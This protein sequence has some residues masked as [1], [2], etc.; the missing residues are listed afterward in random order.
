MSGGLFATGLIGRAAFAAPASTILEYLFFL[1]AYAL[2]G[3]P[4]LLGALRALR[5]GSLFNELS[6]MGVASLGAMAIGELPEAAAV[7]IFYGLGEYLQA[8]A[9]ARSRRSISELMSLRP[10]TVRL[11]AGGTRHS[12]AP[13][14]AAP[15]DI[16]EILPGERVALDGTVL[17]GSSWVDTAPMTGESRPRRLGLGDTVLGGFINGEGRLLA[18][19]DK[20]FG[21]SAA[22]RILELVEKAAARKAPTERFISRFAAVYTPLV[23]AAALLTALLPP[24]LIPDASWRTWIYRALA[25]LMT[26]CP[27]ALVVSIPLAYFG[28]LGG[29][30]R[31]K[32]LI[33]GGTFMDALV[34][35][36][37]VVFDKTGTLT[38]GKF[39][40]RGIYPEPGFTE[41]EI[42][43]LAAAAEAH[44]SHPIGRAI[45]RAAESRASPEGIQAPAVE[46]FSELKGLGVL[47]RIGGR[48]LAVGSPRLLAGQG[49]D[50]PARDSGGSLAHLAVDGVYAGCIEVSDRLKPSA[51]EAVRELRRLGARRILMLTGD[52]AL[53]AQAMAG[54]AGIG[55]VR[56][57]LLPDAK[58]AELDGLAADPARR[59]A[60][61]FIGDGMNDAPVLMRADV[62]IAMGGL[63]SE[64]AV[65]A[66]D[67]VLMDDDLMRLPE[68]LRIARF[69][70][71]V[72]LQNVGMALAVKVLFIGLGAAGL[73]GM[74]EAVIGDVGVALL[75]LFNALRAGSLAAPGRYPRAFRPR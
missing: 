13:E 23:G 32:I 68:A 19:V 53:P 24:L 22:A 61:I 46:E 18:R 25:V 7:M 58:V 34:K 38:E 30:S 37:T 47:A 33:K 59:G 65:E 50:V 44:S 71:R 5:R 10:E 1:S 52:S 75:A 49:L 54:E 31:R 43:S 20:P 69:T 45:L 73:A 42:L 12:V 70:R 67:V 51:A 40:V 6:L 39:E 28:G 14:E 9:E 17:E 36:D 15:G 74:W 57:G 11:F 64:A 3:G 4:V 72:A 8:A 35:V 29:A 16:M 56:A 62:G 55:E 27:C 63:G 21:R 41:A 66:A 60:L 48:R 2:A 26:A